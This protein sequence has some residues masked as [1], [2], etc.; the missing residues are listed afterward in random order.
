[1]QLY[2]PIVEGMVIKN[3]VELYPKRQGEYLGSVRVVSEN[4]VVLAQ[5]MISLTSRDK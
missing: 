3:M 4:N 1:M 2:E 5:S